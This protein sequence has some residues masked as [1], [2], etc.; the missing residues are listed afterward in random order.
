MHSSPD[1]TPSR[2]QCGT[3][4]SLTVGYVAMLALFWLPFEKCN[5]QESHSLTAAMPSIVL[6]LYAASALLRAKWTFPLSSVYS[7]T[8]DENCRISMSHK[9]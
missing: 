5:L 7:V 8:L 6:F 3:R 9:I 2:V 4:F 1:V